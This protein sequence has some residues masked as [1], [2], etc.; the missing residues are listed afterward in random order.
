MPPGSDR[1]PVALRRAVAADAPALLQVAHAAIVGTVPR[2]YSRAQCDA[3]L[4]QLDLMSFARMIGHD[5]VRVADIGG[6]PCGFGSLR[7][8][9]P[10]IDRLFVHPSAAGRGLGSTIISELT[11]K[12][13]SLGLDHLDVRASRAAAGVFDRLGWQLIADEVVRIG[14]NELARSH[15]RR[16][17]HDD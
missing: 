11:D 1:T 15:L 7:V 9:V 6:I 2:F 17:L 16:Q 13:R 3:W 4:G 12:A 10:D 8:S 14:D 5:M